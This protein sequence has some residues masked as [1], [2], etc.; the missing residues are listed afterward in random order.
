M[1]APIPE[2]GD[3]RQT[4]GVSSTALRLIHFAQVL[5]EAGGYQS[6]LSSSKAPQSFVPAPHSTGVIC[7]AWPQPTFYVSAGDLNSNLHGCTG[8][9]LNPLSRH[10]LFS[11]NFI[12]VHS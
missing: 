5:V 6:R 12:G 11:E 9:I 2:Q 1:L 4:R 10:T 3:Q 8:S 7:Y